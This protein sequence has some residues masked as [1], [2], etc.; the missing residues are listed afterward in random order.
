MMETDQKAQ[1]CFCE[2]PQSATTSLENA[3]IAKTL[4]SAMDKGY[5]VVPCKVNIYGFLQKILK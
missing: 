4:N 1:R 3:Q 5:D 2:K